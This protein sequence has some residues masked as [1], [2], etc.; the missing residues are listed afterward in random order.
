M[1]IEVIHYLA[2]SLRQ[3]ART[4][5]VSNH[6]NARFQCLRRL[7]HVWRNWEGQ[8]N[9]PRFTKWTFRQRYR[10]FAGLDQFIFQALRS[11][12][13]RINRIFWILGSFHTNWEVLLADIVA[14]KFL[15]KKD[16]CLQKKWYF[17]LQNRL[18]TRQFPEKIIFYSGISWT[19]QKRRKQKPIL[20][21]ERGFSDL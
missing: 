13:R 19:T 4:W 20:R 10:C 8:V 12:W 6:F 2:N 18:S 3:A 7:P 1:Y 5:E 14:T 21:C 11:W 17:W 16:E 9:A 15:T